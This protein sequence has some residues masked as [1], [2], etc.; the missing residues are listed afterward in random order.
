[1]VEVINVR[2]HINPLTWKQFKVAWQNVLSGHNKY[3]S[4]N[5]TLNGHNTE[6]G[7]DNYVA[8][9]IAFLQDNPDALHH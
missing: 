8:E 2:I 3:E 6:L 5:Q 9:Q 4:E 7:C 1:M